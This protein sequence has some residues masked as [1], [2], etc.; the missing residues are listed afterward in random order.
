MHLLRLALC[1][2]LLSACQDTSKDQ[3]TRPSPDSTATPSAVTL[4]AGRIDG[5]FS[6]QQGMANYQ[7]SL[8]LPP[9]TRGIQ[10]SLSLAYSSG[11]G[12]GLLGVG[13]RLQGISSISRCGAN[14]LTDGFK[15][16]VAY[17]DDDRFCL[18]GQR[19]IQI[20]SDDNNQIWEYRTQ[21][22]SWQRIIAN[23]R[24]GSG[25]CTFTLNRKDGT[26]TT[27]G[28]SNP[29]AIPATGSAPSGSIRRWLQDTT[30]DSNGN[31]LSF[32]YSTS[33]HLDPETT[34]DQSHSG[35]VY[36]DTIRYWPQ[37]AQ[38]PDARMIRFF[39]QQRPD[40]I[41]HYL[42]GGAIT[43]NLRL[44]SLTTSIH[45][46]DAAC[47][48]SCPSQAIMRYTLSYENHQQRSRLRALT[49][50][51]A[52][53]SCLPPT[54][55]SYSDGGN[56]LLPQPASSNIRGNQN[57]YVGDYN[58]DGL[59]DILV[60]SNQGD[61]LYS[62]QPAPS[63]PGFNGGT[64]TGTQ[65]DAFRTLNFG[66]FNG[67]GTTD[68]YAG[69]GTA[70]G[71]TLYLGDDANFNPYPI[72]QQITG[73][74]ILSGDFDGDS[75]TDLLVA[76]KS[77]AT[78]WISSGTDFTACTTQRYPS[79]PSGSNYIA[80][81]NGDG[82][83]DLL[84]I[85]SEGSGTLY[86]SSSDG[87]NASKSA[88]IDNLLD[89]HTWIGD[90]N[91]DG[92][93][94]V[95][96]GGHSSVTIYY[97]TGTSLSPGQPQSLPLN[98]NTNQADPNFTGD[99]NGDGLVDL[100]IS[101][102]GNN[103]G[104]EY[105]YLYLGTGS[106]KDTGN[107]FNCVQDNGDCK[108]IPQQISTADG[109]LGDFNGDGLTDLFNAS[110]SGNYF[111]WA[112]GS[113]QQVTTPNPIADLLT[114]IID[115][116]GGATQIQ[117]QPITNTEI[118]SS[119]IQRGISG[120][121]NPYNATPLSTTFVHPYPVK[122]L[123]SGTFV[124]AAYQQSADSSPAPYRYHYDY[125]YSDAKLNML[126]RGWLGFRQITI[127]D[128][129][130]NA[131]TTR[132]YVQNF[133][134]NGRIHQR[135]TCDS[136]DTLHCADTSPRLRSQALLSWRCADSQSGSQP[137]VHCQVDNK[138]YNPDAT[139]VFYVTP[140]IAVDQDKTLD[141]RVVT[142]FNF[143]NWGNLKRLA[144]L[145]DKND[146]NSL[147][148]YT[149]KTYYP[150]NPDTW[151]F[152]YLHYRKQTSRSDCLN[153]IARWQSD[154]L[155]LNRYAYD[156][157]TGNR[158]QAL[159]WD[160]HNQLW[161]GSQTT[162]SPQGLAATLSELSGNPP[163]PVGNTTYTITR[164]PGFNTYPI[165]L[166]SPNPHSGVDTLQKQYAHD[167]RF[168]I[169]VATSD[170]NGNLI[171]SCLDD[172]GRTIALQ[173]PPP[174]GAPT[175][176]NCL[177]SQR[178]P[179]LAT[180]I[181]SNTQLVTTNRYQYQQDPSQR[182]T[183]LIEQHLTAWDGD[184][185]TEMTRTLDGLGRSIAVS[186]QN[187]QGQD[188]SVVA[189]YLDPN[190]LKR[191]SLPALSG[192]E[193]YWVSYTYDSL[194]RK[195]QLTRPTWDLN[196][197]LSSRINT[198][199]YSPN[200]TLTITQA[201]GSDD[202]VTQIQQLR[203][204]GRQ[205]Q[206]HSAQIQN[207]TTLIQHDA[208]ARVTQV[209]NPTP[210]SGAAVVDHISYDSLGRTLTRG[211]NNAGQISYQY[212]AHGMLCGLSDSLGQVIQFT[213]DSLR[214]PTEQ[215]LYR[216]SGQP[217]GD[218][219]THPQGP[220]ES[221]LA[222]NY[223]LP[224]SGQA[225]NTLG[226]LTQTRQTPA[227]GP[228]IGYDYS[229]D[230]W[231]RT[232]E[233]DLLLGQDHSLAFSMHYDP[234]GRLLSRSYPQFGQQ[235][236]Q[237][238]ASYWPGNGHLNSL[239]YAADGQDFS[240]WL[241]LSDYSAYGQPQSAD[242]TATHS[243]EYWDYQADGLLAA[244]RVQDH[245]NTLLLNHAFGWNQRQSISSILDCN[246]K[247]NAQQPAC[248]QHPG[249][250]ANDDSLY[251]QYDPVQ[252]L[253]GVSG[254]QTA[255]NCYD[256]AGNLLLNQGTHFNYQGNQVHTG[257]SASDP[258]NCQSPSADQVYNAQYNAN[259]AMTQR[260]SGNGLNTQLDFS[261]SVKGWLLQTQLNQQ[262][263]QRSAYDPYGRRVLKTRYQ[264]DGQTLAHA[265]LYLAPDLEIEISQEQ[266]ASYTTYLQDSRGKFAALSQA[267]SNE[268]AQALLQAVGLE[269]ALDTPAVSPQS[270]ALVLHRDQVNSTQLV[271]DSSGNHYASV[272]YD[273]WGV[274]SISPAAN[275]RFRPLFG[276][277]EYDHNTGLYDFNARHYDSFS[278][279][280][281]SADT[282]IAA[283]PLTPDGLN[284]YAYVLNNP[285][286]Y[287]DPSGHFPV[288]AVLG[289]VKASIT[290]A[291]ALTD[292]E[293]FLPEEE[294]LADFAIQQ[295]LEE[296]NTEGDALDTPS[297]SQRTSSSL[298]TDSAS[299]RGGDCHSFIAGT[300]IA[301]QE[302]P[303]AIEDIK[304]GDQVWSYATDS[305]S[306]QLGTVEDSFS[307]L[308]ARQLILTLTDGETLVV[309]P[310]H[311]LY[312]ARANRDF[313]WQ[314]ASELQVGDRLLKLNGE[315]LQISAIQPQQRIRRVYNFSVSPH[316]NYYVSPSQ[317]LAHNIRC[318][319][320][321][322][323]RIRNNTQLEPLGD[324]RIRATTRDAEY[325]GIYE[326]IYSADTWEMKLNMRSALP[327]QNLPPYYAS[328]VALDQ[329]HMASELGG[330]G[331]QRPTRIIR[332]NV[333]NDLTRD[334]FA[335]YEQQG[336]NLY[337]M[338]FEET[339]NGRST[340]FISQ[341]LGLRP[342]SFTYSRNGGAINIV[343]DL[344][345]YD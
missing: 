101:S 37:G 3:L 104:Q 7:L 242:Y 184:D 136:Q 4:S 139:Q 60:S 195:K 329:W 52:A 57:A 331:G 25:P 312:Q 116:Y 2:L 77:S 201:A 131:Q 336:G 166:T 223:D 297:G 53:N 35:Q 304:V 248:L 211:D 33:P 253:K 207:A 120:N 221:T 328:D 186:Y 99:F 84:S 62:G 156:P 127:N 298:A 169:Q 118:Y 198:W 305:G 40:P 228:S 100:Y 137:L 245:S 233:R 264:D 114:G 243:H 287:A 167:A 128:P 163:R 199:D 80:D 279:R 168:G 70:S 149:C 296:T 282:Q 16:G 341:A 226:Q 313:S 145:G 185:W 270:Q 209:T 124:V 79:V 112:V 9:G 320:E 289:L 73:G 315:T 259:G 274:P 13:F 110:A 173:G 307:R 65:L 278:G 244:H 219:C 23:G 172:F 212:D 330:F 309:T 178:Y 232:T 63:T 158:T 280:F 240:T 115:G 165:S 96:V 257:Y 41:L 143:D 48:D 78:A 187:D 106:G 140:S 192:A 231:G 317:I 146:P 150:A 147:A 283:G 208:L 5:S 301:T 224:V 133:P 15:G 160:N 188:F 130:L 72:S 36:L 255:N 121:S 170:A 215:R 258:G 285:I 175:S 308:A 256:N 218:L 306:T 206:V 164:D 268:D 189:H 157:D 294:E 148:L 235:R 234:Q 85:I 154:D 200:N 109:F 92:M 260:Q 95:M 271:T 321:A 11:T 49:Q 153:D 1:L 71:S 103:N 293:E 261:Y 152:G 58:G 83:D 31:T 310:E 239:D 75:R 300:H 225:S 205:A 251:Y 204:Y 190:H 333:V 202:S 28:S 269:M 97:A 338:F 14:I 32:S 180:P 161:L 339:P 295:I 299:S 290:L 252:R 54:L 183:Q 129:Q 266:G 46:D 43:T 216:A 132:S 151:N 68:I 303:K 324:G 56:Q 142:E 220:L 94:D 159:R 302:G 34:S 203:Y 113:K 134:Y 89:V 177:D 343:I 18:N 69:K 144:A 273:P 44:H 284:D 30:T 250:A 126:G 230:A 10:P 67:D 105:G 237:L 19:L 51:S 319:V 326:N 277:K 267:L 249:N 108:Q 286:I 93:A 292:S 27:F 119:H 197:Q 311:P 247:D 288:K 222:F 241:Q 102:I 262:L 38:Y 344:E 74:Q 275:N 196:G 8:M 254:A 335:R 50:C 47:S 155:Q 39:Y 238:Q 340:A 90:F 29:S 59:T 21:K 229:Y 345:Q 91:G 86:F 6:V 342:A 265:T 107:Y 20:S 291:S 26:T 64:P 45:P 66:D 12:N 272:D 337:N 174:A 325:H 181:T 213:W 138:H 171:N 281:I 210:Q 327:G 193:P 323:Q 55:F 236:A 179:Y 24:C 263:Y 122:R 246:A 314:A 111:N 227:Q 61:T 82:R 334:V 182:A 87:C 42:G 81:F 141:N 17:D 276:G 117:Y 176:N 214:R 88:P 332:S 125:H 318:S 191:S 135:N 322:S 76:A 98:N 162:Y 316:P 217:L 22:E 123:H 194:G